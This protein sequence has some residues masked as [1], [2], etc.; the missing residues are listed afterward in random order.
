MKKS[1]LTYVILLSQTFVL[2]SQSQSVHP[3]KI[4]TYTTYLSNFPDDAKKLDWWIPMASSN[5]RQS[6]EVLSIKGLKG[7]I[8]TETKYGNRMYYIGRD[9]KKTKPDDTLRVTITYKVKTAE[10]SVPEAKSLAPLEK[11]IPGEN[12]QVYLGD[13]LLI[14]LKGPVADMYSRL[15]LSPYPIRAARQI[16]DYLIDTMVYNYKAPG[17]GLGDV[18]WACNNLTGDCSDYHSIFIGLCRSHGIPADHG[19]GWPL[20]VS[21]GRTP[22]KYWHCWAKFWVEGPGWITIDASEADKHPEQKD[23]LF[24][25]LNEVYLTISHGRDVILSPAQAGQPLNIF[26]DPYA[27]IDGKKRE[28]IWWI[29][30]VENK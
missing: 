16:Y 11:V 3:E 8:T 10:K 12:M 14:P 27:E 4:F 28:N 1:L 22:V 6:V 24:G 5:E 2:F 19:F 29:G 15:E 7:K 17:A 20:R 26:A 9:L 30:Y 25:T 18:V 13:N 23:Y 21:E